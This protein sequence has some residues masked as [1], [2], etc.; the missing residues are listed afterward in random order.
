MYHTDLSHS[1][2]RACGFTSVV[3]RPLHV[4]AGRGKLW[5]VWRGQLCAHGCFGLFTS[6]GCRF[7]TPD[8][9]PARCVGHQHR[10][11]AEQHATSRP[12]LRD[13]GHCGMHPCCGPLR[14][15]R[16]VGRGRAGAAHELRGGGGGGATCWRSGRGGSCRLPGSPLRRSVAI[17][18]VC[19]PPLLFI[20]CRWPIGRAA[21]LSAH[22]PAHVMHCR[23][24]A[25]VRCTSVSCCSDLVC[26]E[27]RRPMHMRH[28]WH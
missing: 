9:D 15:P 20:V 17:A 7:N 27:S 23:A 4:A 22:E 1:A 13:P 11:K 14:A 10:G 28:L 8:L 25:M 12:C 24:R 6:T 5:R 3:D 18:R 19:A 26:H 2:S 21:L 16:H